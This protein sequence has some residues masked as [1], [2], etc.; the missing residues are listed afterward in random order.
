[1]F[2]SKPNKRWTTRE[3]TAPA[4]CPQCI[5]NILSQFFLA[6]PRFQLSVAIA[7]VVSIVTSLL[8]FYFTRNK[9]GKIQLPGQRDVVDEQIES[10][11]SDATRSE[12]MDGYPIDAERFWKR[13][14]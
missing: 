12:D 3:S 1:M 2:G 10:D 11:I 8:T 4:F 5:L 13:V 9:E 7:L 14:C 6:M